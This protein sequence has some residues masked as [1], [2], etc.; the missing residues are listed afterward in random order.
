MSRAVVVTVRLPDEGTR[1]EPLVSGE[2][3][4][5]FTEAPSYDQLSAAL[6]LLSKDLLLVGAD[7]V[8]VGEGDEMHEITRVTHN[9]VAALGVHIGWQ[10]I[11]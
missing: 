9:E 4:S 7:R 2:V 1:L 11:A 8:H 10:V 3:N 5:R 6:Y